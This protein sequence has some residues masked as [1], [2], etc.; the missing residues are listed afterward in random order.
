[1]TTTQR[2]AGVDPSDEALM[3]RLRYGDDLALNSLMQRW[4]RP[5][6]GFILRYTNN[7]TDSTD[8]AQETFVRIYENRVRYRPKGKFSTWMFTIAANLCRNH[9]RW[10]SRHPSVSTVSTGSD[11]DEN[12][13]SDTIA[14]PAQ[15]PDER[16]ISGDEAQKIR[17]AVQGLPH[18]LRTAVWRAAPR[19]RSNVRFGDLHRS[20][21]RVLRLSFFRE[22]PS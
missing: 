22:T 8:L 1:M 11:G 13:W 3:L 2:E 9:A 17:E 16:A 19:V 7:R 20:Y 14:D 18:T 10:K 21:R 12:D 15:Q 4:E 6:V 5:L